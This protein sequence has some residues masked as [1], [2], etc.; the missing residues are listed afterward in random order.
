[1]V[2]HGRNW[3]QVVDLFHLDPDPL[4][5]TDTVIDIRRALEV[6]EYGA[7]VLGN[8]ALAFDMF[9][10][11]PIGYG[12]SFDYIALSAPTFRDSLKNWERFYPTRTNCITLVFEEGED[13]CI[14]R[15]NLPQHYGKCSQIT[16]AF[17]AWTVARMERIIGSEVRHLE[18]DLAVPA[19]ATQVPFVKRFRQSL[20]FDRPVTR[21]T[22]PNELLG[23]KPPTAEPNLFTIVETAA[24]KELDERRGPASGTAAIAAEIGLQLKSGHCSM[25]SVATALGTST[26]SMQRALEG[27]GTSYRRILEDVR[28]SMA[29]RYLS[30]TDVPIKEI[31]YLLGFSEISAFSRAVK[32]WFGQPPRAVRQGSQESDGIP[33]SN[34]AYV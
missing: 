34:G 1:M 11:P 17:V 15:W 28:K 31:A 12:N 23:V 4:T 8:D 7:S 3:N 25:E 9:A 24:L 33:P 26:R 13:Q 18:I 2:S 29:E 14:L 27:E 20:L 10:D 21:I 16:Y 22:I 32:S 6:M 19:P 5:R 30:D